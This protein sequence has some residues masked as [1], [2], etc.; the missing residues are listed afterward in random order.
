MTRILY[1]LCTA[2]P[3][4]RPSPYCWLVKFALLHKGLDF[5]TVP[6]PFADKSKY[7]DP[8]YGKVP[9]LKDG[10]ELVRD[11]AVIVDHLE[12]VYPQRPLTRTAGE[13]AGAGFIAAW[14]RSAIYPA[15]APLTIPL[16]AVAL[17]GEDLAYFRR[18]REERFGKPL[19]EA[20]KDPTA[21]ERMEAA[22]GL[23]ASPLSDHGFLGGDGPGL[24]DYIVFSALMWRRTIAHSDPYET[25]PEIAA[26]SE[27][28]LDL[29]D[30]YAR[31]AKRAV[32]A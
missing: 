1:D 22:L 21:A 19:E 16:V 10:D 17:D 24:S 23:L 2:D 28:M 11:S 3:D 13:R 31:K 7:P 30:G 4:V 32:A 20:A 6:L 18:T 29:Y 8:D 5:E 14:V 9:M 27:R 15:L 25:P 12:H 26:W